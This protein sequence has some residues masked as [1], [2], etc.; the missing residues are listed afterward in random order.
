MPAV[1]ENTA[2][3]PRTNDDRSEIPWEELSCSAR[4]TLTSL[5]RLFLHGG[6]YSARIEIHDGGRRDFKVETSPETILGTDP[7]SG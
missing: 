7:R 1:P 4:E 2:L 6:T 3:R 5:A